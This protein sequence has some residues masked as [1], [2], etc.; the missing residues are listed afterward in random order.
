MNLSIKENELFASF[1]AIKTL[2]NKINNFQIFYDFTN[3]CGKIHFE[4]DEC[5]DF[6]IGGYT[7]DKTSISIKINFRDIDVMLSQKTTKDDIKT[8]SVIEIQNDMGTFVWHDYNKEC[9]FLYPEKCLIKLNDYMEDYNNWY[10]LNIVENTIKISEFEYECREFEP[11]EEDF[12]K[13]NDV[14]L[15]YLR[16]SDII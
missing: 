10:K 12:T 9:I 6:K 16:L 14:Y 4:E 2:V 13:W 1:E 11:I 5:Y 3:K 7:K 8:I 15:F